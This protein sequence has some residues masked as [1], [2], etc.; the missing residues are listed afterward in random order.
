MR[1]TGGG[2]GCGDGAATL[3]ANDDDEAPKLQEMKS[4][5]TGSS[6]T[7][8]ASLQPATAVNVN[9][10]HAAH[11]ELALAAISLFFV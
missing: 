6:E 11:C 3:N 4:T 5:Y 2:A 10:K 8:V 9:M 1:E 7:L